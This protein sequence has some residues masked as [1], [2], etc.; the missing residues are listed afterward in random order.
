MKLVIGVINV[1]PDSFS[2]GGDYFDARLAIAKGYQ[3]IEDGCGI[4][5][6]GGESTRPGA[7]PTDEEEE[8][9]RI[10]PVI[11]ELSKAVRISVDTAKA[12]VARRAVEA[13]ATILNDISASLA[14]VAAR[15][16]V[17]WLAMHM[18][19]NPRTMQDKPHYH[20]VVS[21][22]CGFLAERAKWATELG[23]SEVWVDPGI[24]F[25]KTSEHNL[26]LLANIDHVVALGHPVVVG[27][28]RKGF[29]GR[30]A[31]S[32][33]GAVPPPKDRLEGSLAT[34]AWCYANGVT[35]MRVHDVAET[36]QLLGL[37]AY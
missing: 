15:E 28:S 27:T 32:F 2:D 1:T 5:D 30:I 9:R 6:V 23:I 14:E 31:A 29:L 22:V 24:G 18:Q 35:A 19:G 26:E 17:A 10:L 33:E 13:G 20:D 36:A 34:A 25:G 12:S 4:I 7:V 3:M 8:A 16:G 21:E 11:A 37:G